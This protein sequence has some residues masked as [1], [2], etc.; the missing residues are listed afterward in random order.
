MLALLLAVSCIGC[1]EGRLR[2][3]H[4]NTVAVS[5]RTVVSGRSAQDGGGLRPQGI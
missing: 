1:L 2:L 4:E 3:G 5:K